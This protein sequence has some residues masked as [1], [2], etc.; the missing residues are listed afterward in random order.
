MSVDTI[1]Q[2]YCIVTMSSVKKTL[3]LRLRRPMLHPDEKNTAFYTIPEI[4]KENYLKCI[5]PLYDILENK[6]KSKSQIDQFAK[7]CWKS[8]YDETDEDWIMNNEKTQ[9]ERAW[10]MAWGNFHQNIMGS[11]SDWENYEI[12]HETGCD[13]GRK[14]G[15]CIA[16]IKNNTNTMNSSSKDSVIRKLRIQAELGKR[17]L[18]IVVNGEIKRSVILN[19][20][21]TMSG[22]DFYH[23]LSGR[24][25]FME[26]LLETVKYSFHNYKTYDELKAVLE[27][28]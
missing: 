27:I 14:D 1:I 20:I 8:Y 25:D 9:K 17:A 24:E 10:T 11:F 15:T 5:R 18:L 3:G 16:E 4:S 13:I 23:E 2:H 19:I 26:N 22:K 12:G 28:V 6:N 7:E 21:E